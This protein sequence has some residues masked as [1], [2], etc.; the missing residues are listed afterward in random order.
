MNQTRDALVV[1]HLEK[2][3]GDARVI[4]DFSFAVAEQ[5]LVTIVGPSGAGKSTLVRCCAGLLRPGSG[6]VEVAGSPI[7]KRPPA[8]LM[9]VFQDYSRSLFPWMTVEHNVTIGLRERGL[10]ARDARAR[11]GEVLAAVGLEGR[12]KLHPWQL[13]GGMQQRVAI[14]RA[15]A[16]RPKILLLDE[17]FGSVDAQTRADLEDLLLAVWEQY[18]MTVVVITHDMDEAVYL[19]DRVLVTTAAPLRLKREIP[20]ELPRPR[21]Q[22]ATKTAARYAERRAEVFAA[23]RNDGGTPEEAARTAAGAPESGMVL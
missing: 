5:E 19:A 9:V 3:Y 7:G 11:A 17:P 22:L 13:S 4:D 10:G 12:G 16:L 20:I 8:E 2:S 18:R 15:L 6:R 1:E 23:L 14:A 21:D